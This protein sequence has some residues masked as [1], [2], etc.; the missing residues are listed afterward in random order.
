M[1]RNTLGLFLILIAVIITVT[2]SYQNSDRRQQALVFSKNDMLD[3]LWDKY[4][5][6]Y[7]EPESNRTLDKQ[8]DNITTSEGQSYSMLRAVW[9]DDKSAFDAS[10]K[11]TKDNLDRPNDRLFSWLYGRANDGTYGIIKEKGGMNT[12]TDADIDIAVALL[13]A[14]KRWGDTTYFD[15][16]KSIIEDIWEKEV[17]IINN[18]PYIVASSTETVSDSETAVV[19]PSYLAPYAYRM[20]AKVD[21]NHDWNKVVDTSY[22][23]IQT[24]AE[25][26]LDKS[27][28]AGLPPDWV[29]INKKSGIITPATGTNLTSNF[30]YDAMRTIWRLSLDWQWYKDPRAR[31]TLE[32]FKFLS[33][34]WEQNGKVMAEYSHDGQVVGNYESP[35][36][37][38]GVI[39]YF[40][41]TDPVLG[42]KVYTTKLKSLY[43]TDTRSWAQP[44][45]YYEDNWA[46]FGI[47]LAEQK[48]PLL[49]Q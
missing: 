30:S 47:A 20:F 1:N 32:K 44:L 49:Y 38:G 42:E 4:K 36:I 18:E 22:A 10:W 39:G 5:Q 14:S 11:W 26:N 12:A 48:L 19:N 13:F 27:S 6:N 37:Y 40:L 43:S 7:F 21:S 17:L 23:I 31:E 25:S 15:D 28:S 34:E 29:Y 41:I 3:A 33:T 16:A 8:R 2:V 35:A 24:S 45:G 46:W 9:S